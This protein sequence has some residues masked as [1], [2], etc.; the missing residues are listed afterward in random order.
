MFTLSALVLQLVYVTNSSKP[1]SFSSTFPPRYEISK[2]E[3]KRFVL[4]H[5]SMNG[6][7]CVC[8]LY[9]FIGGTAVEP[10][11][12]LVLRLESKLIKDKF[13]KD[14]GPFIDYI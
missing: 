9:R 11:A 12:F 3:V 8:E 13:P 5:N 10:R 7:C 1:S 4:V 14:L 2:C 6:I